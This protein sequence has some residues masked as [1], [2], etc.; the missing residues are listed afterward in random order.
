MKNARQLVAPITLGVPAS[1][2]LWLIFIGTFALH[3]LLIGAVATVLAIAGLCLIN[4]HYPARFA[5][6]VGELLSLWR[7]PWYLVSGTWEIMKVGAMDWMG[8][9]RA[10]SLFRVAPF[11]AGKKDDPTAVARR[12]LA[13]TYT[14][15]APN[16]IVLGINA[17]NQQL[18]FHQI[19]RGAVPKMTQDLGALP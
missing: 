5:P 4:V 7:L 16:F 6:S 13:V 15:A 12:V 2:L 10:K 18:L 19:E 9:E 3:E 1:Y 14:T 8:L 17:N 11:N